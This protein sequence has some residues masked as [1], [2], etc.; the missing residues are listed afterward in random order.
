MQDAYE[1]MSKDDQSKVDE[2][3]DACDMSELLGLRLN[4]EIGRANNLEVWL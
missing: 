2:L 1:A 4:R 3:L